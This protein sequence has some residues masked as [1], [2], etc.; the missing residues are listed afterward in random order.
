MT[1]DFDLTARAKELALA[2]GFLRVGV[3]R[4]EPL[5]EEAMRLSAWLSKGRHADMDYMQDTFVVRT[6]PTQSRMLEGATSM[7]VLVAPYASP[8]SETPMRG[9]ASVA[10]YALG[11][12]YHRVLKKRAKPLVEMFTAAGFE[13]RLAVDVLPVFERAWA[14]RS[15]VGFVGKNACLIVPGVGSYVFLAVL[16][17]TAPLQPDAPMRERCGTCVRCLQACPTEAFA[18]AG[19][20]DAAKC[21]SY[22]T[23]E[24]RGPI[25]ASLRSKMGSWMF[26]CDAC[27]EVCPFND[28]RGETLSEAS[29]SMLAEFS[30][31]GIAGGP[32]EFLQMQD[33]AF[34]VMS[35]GVS[36]RR[37][38]RE[39]MARNAAVVLGNVGS[40]VHLK[41]LHDAAT[42]DPSPIVREA[43]EWAATQ[44]TRRVG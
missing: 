5:T 34:E 14:V 24:N 8:R 23:I 19:D 20:L 2:Q 36:L 42:N 28:A 32:V 35:R 33:E 22:L 16:V 3:A 38:K 6:D 31:G 26:G 21:I 37:A 27:Q 9:E 18:G 17:T 29:Q 43:A 7:L 15:G 40:R 25:P 12:D 39:G 11:R 44:I 1:S 4:A 13:A 10:R 41:V 30:G